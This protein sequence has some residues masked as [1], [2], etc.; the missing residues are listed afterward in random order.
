MSFGEPATATWDI[1]IPQD[2]NNEYS[3]HIQMGL[4]MVVTGLIFIMLASPLS[5]HYKEEQIPPIA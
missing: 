4:G 3:H 1:D 2:T 5:Q